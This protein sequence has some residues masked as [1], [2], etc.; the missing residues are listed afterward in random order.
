MF[1]I[2]KGDIMADKKTQPKKKLYTTLDNKPFDE[3][4]DEWESHWDEDHKDYTKVKEKHNEES[5][6]LKS[7]YQKAENKAFVEIHGSKEDGK[8]PIKRSFAGVK[9]SDIEAKVEHMLLSISLEHIKNKFGE[10]AAKDSVKNLEHVKDH[11]NQLVSGLMG[12]Q[13][14]YMALKK[15][16]IQHKEDFSI[17]QKGLYSQIMNALYNDTKISQDARHL[18]ESISD[19]KH[20]EVF[21]DKFKKT[22]KSHELVGSPVIDELVNMYKI[23]KPAGKIKQMEARE[24]GK[25]LKYIESEKK[26]KKK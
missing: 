6:D 3:L 7:R 16:I 4:L 13:G 26:Y 2:I 5:L 17:D 22:V 10:N 24:F 15:Y 21:K 18:E 23:A 9:D 11:L 19:V 14:G 25:N 1:Y 8:T 20:Y 12:R